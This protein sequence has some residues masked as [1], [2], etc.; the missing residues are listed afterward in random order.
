VQQ[1]TPM[2]TALRLLCAAVVMMALPLPGHALD[3]R[4]PAPANQTFARTEAL[5]SFSL[6]VGPFADGTTKTELIEGALSQ[7]AWSLQAKGL[8]TL[9]LFA[10]LRDQLTTAGYTVLFECETFACGGFDFR[11]GIDIAA[12]PAMHVDLGDF[13]YLAAKR[14]GPNGLEHIALVVSRSSTLGFVQLTQIGEASAA[15]AVAEIPAVPIED[16]A[17]PPVV[18]DNSPMGE[19]LAKQGSVALDD[20]IFASG[21]ADLAPG[22]YASLDALSKFLR[23][24]PATKVA[25]VGHTDA[26]GSLAGNVALS[27][28]RAESVRNR[29]IESYAIPADQITAEGVGYLAPRDS[30]LTESGLTRNR[31]VE[32]M[33]LVNP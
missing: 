14:T 17:T 22:E 25:L 32:V 5:T 8:T 1:T 27:R 18:V 9:Q 6:A 15:P 30:N 3:L 13:R 7:T 24:N 20:L 10:P 4:F 16:P 23:A 11:F 12:E 26:S 2:R 21:A 28:K 31:R 19:G 33:L 29:L